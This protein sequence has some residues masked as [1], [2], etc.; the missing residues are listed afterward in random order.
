[1]TLSSYR[2][3]FVVLAVS[4]AFGCSRPHAASGRAQG[5]GEA[6]SGNAGVTTAEAGAP[7]DADHDGGV[8]TM[9]VD[10]GLLD[11]AG[12][13]RDAGGPVGSKGQ[14]GAAG[15]KVGGGQAGAW[16]SDP[17]CNS[18]PGHC[19][20]VCDADGINCPC[21]CDCRLDVDCQRLS[22]AVACVPLHEPSPPCC[23]TGPQCGPGRGCPK[24]SGTATLCSGGPCASCVPPCMSD[25]GCGDGLRCNADQLCIRKR[26]DTDGYPCA[27]HSACS[28]ADPNA[29]SR[30]CLHDRCATDADCEP[31]ACVNGR[32]ADG[33]GRCVPT[34]CG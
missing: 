3:V 24:V 22:P 11:D 8:G 1:M 29:D 4:T 27:A 10:S 28:G 6:G 12:T 2:I 15:G 14:A 31:G 17:A 21:N 33:P 30:G 18:F 5:G 13:H 7:R 19:I 23:G 26:C 25:S 20:K 16:S 9:H 32:C 34:S